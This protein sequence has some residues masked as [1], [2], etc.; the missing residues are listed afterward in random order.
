MSTPTIARQL[1]RFIHS[2]SF[3]D[4]PAKVIE[5]AK[6]RIL[7][8]LGTALA[9]RELPVPST[10]LKFVQGNGGTGESTIFGHPR[11]VA[12]IDAA[13]VNATLVN[14]TTHD[15]F[16]DKSHPGAVTVPAAIAL[17]EET[18]RSG[19]EVLGA[20]VLGYDLTGR[21]W[22]GGPSMLP[23]FRA[24]GVAGAI[25]AAATAG[26]LLELEEDGLASALGLAGMFA[27]GFGEGFLSGTMDVKLNV[28][29]ACRSGVSAA[30]LAQCGASA[31]PL[32]FE[33][34]SGFYQAFAGTTEHAANAVGEFGT[35]FLIEQ[36]VYKERPVCIF[37]QTPVELARALVDEHEID[38]TAIE[39]V[40]IHAPHA[41]FTNPG[42]RN[43]APFRT[44]L[45]ARISARFTTAAALLRRPIDEYAFY[46]DTG[47]P[48][49]LALAERIELV[50]VGPGT[51][52][53]RLD[54]VCADCT[55]TKQAVEMDSLR[56]TLQKSEIKFRRVA[57]EWL[58]ARTTQ[59]IEAVLGLDSIGDIRE[60]TMLLRSRHHTV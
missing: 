42:F 3:N 52:E 8:S 16:L 12:A 25:G 2:T 30:K 18:G 11:R 32:A 53:V 58:G 40:I 46:Y 19:R 27:S 48:Q 13:F 56:P 4:V 55:L 36:S 20:V 44:H 49:V 10:A 1:A 35:P 5:D 28:G 7:D 38:A 6:S 60:L 9:S 50:D 45:Q 41:T 54:I 24:S 43:S 59:V 23:K 31:A 33:G 39:R 37:V 26:K 57:G 34:A 14:G 15:D 17:A 47:D 51:G 22:R 29:W 21:A